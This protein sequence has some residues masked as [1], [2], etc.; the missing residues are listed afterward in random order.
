M[1]G[2]IS[3]VP[4]AILQTVLTAYSTNL[5]LLR[6]IVRQ[7]AH[8][9]AVHFSDCVAWQLRRADVPVLPAPSSSAQDGGSQTSQSTA[10]HRP[11]CAYA[12]L[13]ATWRLGLMCACG[14]ERRQIVTQLHD[15]AKQADYA[16][17]SR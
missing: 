11:R 14:L 5:Q 3:T 10:M 15:L 16:G 2:V 17:V 4:V 6:M 8:A 12:R 1:P 7:G 13:I 9:H